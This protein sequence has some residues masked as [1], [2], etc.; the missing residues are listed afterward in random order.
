MNRT[1]QTNKY[2]MTKLWMKM[3]VVMHWK[4]LTLRVPNGPITNLNL[5]SR[6]YALSLSEQGIFW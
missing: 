2:Q 1:K 3:S 4:L 6:V 5:K